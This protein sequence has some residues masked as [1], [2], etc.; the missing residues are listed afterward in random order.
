M[1]KELSEYLRVIT[2]ASYNNV[3]KRLDK[4]GLVKGQAYLLV[5]IKDNDGCTQK[6]LSELL[7]V[8]CS[9]MSERLNKL[10]EMGY[11]ERAIDENNSKFKRIFITQT[12]KVAAVQCRRIQNEFNQVLYKGFTKKEIKQLENYLDRL[13]KNVSND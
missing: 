9:S 6:D 5:L 4:Y 2:Q 12:G 11:I 7:N 13:Y 1:E 8:K 3:E 10:E